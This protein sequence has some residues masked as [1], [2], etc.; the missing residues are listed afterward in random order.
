[1]FDILTKP[2]FLFQYVICILLIFE[3]LV[4]FAVINICFSVLTTSINYYLLYRSFTKIKEM[5]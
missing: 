1:M 2:L 4:L 3:R 5:A